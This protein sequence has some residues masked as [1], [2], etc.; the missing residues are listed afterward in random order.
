MKPKKVEL[1]KLEGCKYCTRLC[2]YNKNNI[3]IKEVAIQS[4]NL[5]FN[6]NNLELLK[7]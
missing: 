3:A 2:L 5:K 4:K 7:K 1:F 6:C